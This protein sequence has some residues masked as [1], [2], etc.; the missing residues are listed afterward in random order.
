MNLISNKNLNLVSAGNAQTVAED[1]CHDAAKAFIEKYI[2]APADQ[3][4]A[5]F[6]ANYPKVKQ[7]CA[8]AAL[9]EKYL[10]LTD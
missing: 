2:S 5:I 8:V 4:T 6:K 9:A 3:Q 1:M 7:I 10:S